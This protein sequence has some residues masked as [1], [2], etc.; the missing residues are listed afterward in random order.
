MTRKVLGWCLTLIAFI[1]LAT[2]VVDSSVIAGEQSV[3]YQVALKAKAA[4]AEK[5]KNVQALIECAF[6]YYPM[7]ISAK[8]KNPQY[9]ALL[10]KA[11]EIVLEKKN[12]DQAAA[13]LE[14][15]GPLMGSIKRDFSEKI[16]K[17]ATGKTGAE[18][19]KD[20]AEVARGPIQKA[21]KDFFNPEVKI[22]DRGL[23]TALGKGIV[24]AAHPTGQRPGLINYK[25]TNDGPTRMTVSITIEYF[26]ALTGWRYVADIDIDFAIHNGRAEITF[27]GYND[28]N[29]VP[30]HE[31]NLRDYKDNFNRGR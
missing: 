17:V 26:G 6:G 21:G 14:L 23:M 1:P 10:N 25:V 29:I 20:E 19:A 12:K 11:A 28:N 15:T 22:R 16:T 30:P 2:L 13:F 8:T 31:R 18:I 5:D 9:S 24:L 3:A 7:E 4:K 27:L